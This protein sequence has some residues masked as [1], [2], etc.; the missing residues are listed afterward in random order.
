MPRGRLDLRPEMGHVEV[1]EVKTSP[2]RMS[3]RSSVALY[4]PPQAPDEQELVPAAVFALARM[5]QRGFTLLLAARFL[6]LGPS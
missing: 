3:S 4:I 5:I 6:E 1:D 2:V